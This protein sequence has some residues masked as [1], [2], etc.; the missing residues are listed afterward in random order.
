ME[1]SLTLLTEVPGVVLFEVDSV[2][3]H[4]TGVTATRRMLSVTTDTT[5][6]HRN[7]TSKFSCLA[8][9][10]HLKCLS[11]LNVP[12]NFR[13]IITI[14]QFSIKPISMPF[15]GGICGAK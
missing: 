3:M 12:F 15:R 1:V 6:T 8:Q 13:L 10:M 5:V 7:L 2:V 9:V 11:V 4:T 14:N